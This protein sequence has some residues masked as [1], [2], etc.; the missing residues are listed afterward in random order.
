VT[1]HKQAERTAPGD[2]RAAFDAALFRRSP[3]SEFLEFW[4]F[5]IHFA[6]Y[7][8][9]PFD[10]A[11][12]IEKAKESKQDGGLCLKR[13]TIYD[14]IQFLEN[15][16]LWREDGGGCY[17]MSPLGDRFQ[18]SGNDPPAV[19]EGVGSAGNFV[20]RDNS[21][22]FQKTGNSTI[23]GTVLRTTVPPVPSESARAAVPT[24]P[25]VPAQSAGAFQK[26]GNEPPAKEGTDA[27]RTWEEGNAASADDALHSIL[28]KAHEWQRKIKDRSV[29]PWQVIVPALLLWEGRIREKDVSDLIEYCKSARNPGKAFSGAIRSKLPIDVQGV[30]ITYGIRRF[31]ELG[32]TWEAS[33]SNPRAP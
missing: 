8:D 9:G 6:G 29:F 27:E 1:L 5:A 11:R 33:W 2:G 7:S 16:C 13:Q 25:P 18:K 3:S 17:V 14:R 24:V 26:I 22:A 23:H 21:S 4:L 19:A 31:R 15:F 20:G 30:E 28:G 32:W 12:F 10:K